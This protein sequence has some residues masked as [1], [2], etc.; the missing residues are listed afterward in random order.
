VRLA[1]CQIN[2]V[3]GDPRH[4]LGRI[5]AFAERARA[6]GAQAA[7][8]PE[9]ALPGYLP[10]D[11]L[12]RP[13]F[14]DALV[15]WEQEL[16]RRMPPGIDLVYGS[17]SRAPETGFGKMLVNEAVLARDGVVVARRAKSLLPT[18]DVFDEARYFRP[19]ARGDCGAI[20]HRGQ[21]WGITICEDIWVDQ[22][23]DLE[24]PR[25]DADPAAE[26]AATGASFLLNLSASPYRLGRPA[27]R[28]RLASD[29][30]RRCGLPLALVNLVGGNDELVFD[31]ASVAVDREG[32]VLCRLATAAEDF[33]IVDL[34]A[35]GEAGPPEVSPMAS[36]D[37][38]E[39]RRNLVLG[40][41][42]YV[43]KSGFERV[44]LGLSGGIDSA[45]VAALAA[46]A[47]GP[48]R[49]LGVAMPSRYSA[50]MS[51]EDARSLASKLGIDFEVLAI[52]PAF[53]AMEGILRAPL[54]G[55]PTGLTLE[56]LQP[57][58]RGT[59]LM[60]LANEKRA[61]LLA[62]GNKSELAVGYC[63]LYGDM[64]GALAVIS[65]LWKTEVFALARHLN[66]E[67]E[68]IPWRTIE[69]PPSAE[70][71]P[72]QKDS[73]SLPDY[74]ILD[75]ILDRFLVRQESESAIV[76]AGHEP[77]LVRDVLDRV[78]RNEHKRRQMPPGLRV[79]A[80]AFGF[81][82]RMPLTS[83]PQ[84]VEYPQMRGETE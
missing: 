52:A 34:Q 14:I 32:R 53:E 81:G 64:C 1:L 77:K 10:G 63:T 6:G 24:V 40:L 15:A 18:Y 8:F 42:D 54:G 13:D 25:Y 59:L 2:T 22:A 27:V 12:N 26:A 5:L 38:E 50:S 30:A 60:A 70:L 74:E 78:W 48:G 79:S 62:T 35:P 61:L 11:N 4:N 17:V 51:E 73:D 36:F 69:R 44:V 9:L 71:R 45:L 7:L 57:R 55:D 3:Q 29:T 16:L 19:A 47:L 72:D 46:E 31:G 75:E 39:I 76:S 33:Q 56:N 83:G 37:P 41:R 49:V 68:V 80:K 58:L 28:A 84:R 21:Q 20:D 23:A 43:H 65:D 82:R 67:A 66:R